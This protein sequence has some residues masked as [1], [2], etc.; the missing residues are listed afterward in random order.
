MNEVKVLL[1]DD[2]EGKPFKLPSFG[3]RLTAIFVEPKVVFDF[4]AHR[5]DFWY[6]FIGLVVLMSIGGIL[7]IPTAQKTQQLMLAVRGIDAGEKP[8][9]FLT[10]LMVPLQQAL[11]LMIMLAIFGAITWIIVLMVSGG[12]T[13]AKA[14][15]VIA[16]CSYPSALMTLVNGVVVAITRPE[17]TSIQSS[18]VEASPVMHYTSLAALV[19]V[20]NAYFSMGLAAISLFSLWFFWLLY[21]GVRRSLEG[22]AAAAIVLIIVLL[23]IQ[24]GLSVFGAWGLSKAAG[25]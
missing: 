7:A 10:Y 15:N 6:S 22:K 11:G 18:V 5:T 1:T 20:G 24:V 16:W 12:S 2:E 4:I 13:Y 3:E 17:I 23:V 19:P 14:I 9:T 25:L 8:I 21:I